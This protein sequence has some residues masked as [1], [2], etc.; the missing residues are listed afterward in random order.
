MS[1]FQGRWFT[2]CFHIPSQRWRPWQSTGG[3]WGFQHP[4]ECCWRVGDSFEMLQWSTISVLFPMREINKPIT[5]YCSFA[6]ERNMRAKRDIQNE[7]MWI[8]E[9]QMKWMLPSQLNRNLSNCEVAQKNVFRGFN[10]IRTRGL[11]VPA[12]A[13]YQ[14]S[15]EDPYTEGR[16]T[17]WVHQPV[18]GWNTAEWN[19]MNCGNTNEMN[20][21]PSQLNRNV[22]N[23][24]VT[25]KRF[26][27]A[28]TGFK[29]VA[30]SSICQLHKL[31]RC[32]EGFKEIPFAQNEDKKKR[33]T[34]IFSNHLLLS[35]LP[36]AL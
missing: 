1:S 25:R 35:I 36:L 32:G 29:P 28:S 15:Y 16:P 23:C 33:E 13:L 8:A 14:L 10:G 26:F 7:M 21:W 24:E 11:C 4:T 5:F 19:D 20:M 17:Y 27:G 31:P 2:H 18:K 3:G 6:L 12:A 22:N 9:I 30:S 34:A